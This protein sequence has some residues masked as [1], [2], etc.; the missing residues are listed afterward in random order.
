[1]DRD[2]IYNAISNGDYQYQTMKR[3][4]KENLYDLFIQIGV[5][6]YRIAS[7]NNKNKRLIIPF[8]DLYIPSREILAGFVEIVESELKEQL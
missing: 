8:P 4:Y 1:M 7:Y 2:I 3:N 6:C 5:N